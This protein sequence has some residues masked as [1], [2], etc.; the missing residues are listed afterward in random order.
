MSAGSVLQLRGLHGR[1]DFGW[2]LEWMDC[3]DRI[4]TGVCE[5]TEMTE[6]YFRS[7]SEMD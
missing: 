3:M 1:T 4:D 6:Y 2:S 7:L 5:C